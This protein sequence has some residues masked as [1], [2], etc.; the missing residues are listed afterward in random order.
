MIDVGS[1]GNLA[2]APFSLYDSTTLA[3]ITGHTFVVGEVRV[4]LPGGA[5]ADADVANVTEWGHGQYGL[6][7][8]TTQTANAGQVG[9][10]IN[11]TGAMND[12]SYVTIKAAPVSAAS[13]VAALMAYS[14]D[15]GVTVKGLY[16]RLDALVAGKATGLRSTLARYFM[17]DGTTVAISAVQDVATGTRAVADVTGSEA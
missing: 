11:V 2:E 7:L 14:Y 10:Y 16:R 5:F 13:I 12:Y 8:T 6:K 17:R 1:S 3:P 15:T 9:I 4:R